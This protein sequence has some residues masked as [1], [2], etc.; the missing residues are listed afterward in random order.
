MVPRLTAENRLTSAEKI[1]CDPFFFFFP[2]P[3]PPRKHFIENI[4]TGLPGVGLSKAQGPPPSVRGL[5]D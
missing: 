2:T 3:H 1:F 5:Q 4:R